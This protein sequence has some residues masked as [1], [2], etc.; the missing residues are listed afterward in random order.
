MK[1]SF[2][3]QGSAH[4]L[5]LARDGMTLV[6]VLV[7]LIIAT[8]TIGGIVGGYIFCSTSTEKT[9]FAQLASAKAMERIEETRSAIWDT[10]SYPVVDQLLATNFPATNVL[11]NIVGSGSSGSLATL[12]TSI[13]QIST[14]PP[15]RRVRVD[16]AWQFRGT[17]WMTNTIETIRAPDQ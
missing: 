14:T 9:E 16:C 12:T 10:A 11:L 2:P 17:D 1:T 4:F 15:L 7:S 5:T 8:L 3:N 13:S 6:E